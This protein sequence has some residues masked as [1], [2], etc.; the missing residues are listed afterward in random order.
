MGIILSKFAQQRGAEVIS[1]SPK[2]HNDNHQR[3][4]DDGQQ[5]QDLKQ[6][7]HPDNSSPVSNSKNDQKQQQVPKDL[8]SSSQSH[9]YQR[10]QKVRA[11]R[12]DGPKL[13]PPLNYNPPKASMC[14]E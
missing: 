4:D 2:T 6:D 12:E 14:F 5:Q 13:L 1:Q 8:S 3:F 9:S 7:S 11:N 10:K